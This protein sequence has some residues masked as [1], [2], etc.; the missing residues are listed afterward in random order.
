MG[1]EGGRKEGKKERCLETVL[2][3]QPHKGEEIED[4]KPRMPIGPLG[5]NAL[6]H[7]EAPFNRL[8]SGKLMTSSK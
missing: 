1:R 8:C 4:R 2:A 5:S 6:I 7:L 3:G